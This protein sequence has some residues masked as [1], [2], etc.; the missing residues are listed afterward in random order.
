MLILVIHSLKRVIHIL[1]L[2]KVQKV[3]HSKSYPQ[4]YP[5]PW[6][7]LCILCLHYAQTRSNINGTFLGSD[8]GNRVFM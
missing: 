1:I 7:W 2:L 8:P 6:A 4:N 3:H 5:Q